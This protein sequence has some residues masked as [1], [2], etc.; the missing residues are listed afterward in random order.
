[1]ITLP[2]GTQAPMMTKEDVAKKKLDPKS[3]IN[4]KALENFLKAKPTPKS[5]TP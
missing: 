2:D 4:P 5:G 1:M 3:K